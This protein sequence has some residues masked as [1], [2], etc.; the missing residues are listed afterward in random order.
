MRYEKNLNSVFKRQLDMT[1]RIYFDI[2]KDELKLVAV[3]VD[4]SLISNGNG[5]KIQMVMLFGFIRWINAYS[6]ENS[7]KT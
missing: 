1:K 6:K 5:N 2:L 7:I 3:R 4:V